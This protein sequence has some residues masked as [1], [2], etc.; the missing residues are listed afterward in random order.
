MSPSP[1]A[2]DIHNP[3]NQTDQQK[4]ISH[5]GNIIIK[6]QSAK[7]KV[8][9]PVIPNAGSNQ[10]K[11]SNQDLN[12]VLKDQQSPLQSVFISNESADNK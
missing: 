2:P 10:S 9:S 8:Q 3:H 1:S 6:S 12:N 4:E 5:S 11:Q 7:R